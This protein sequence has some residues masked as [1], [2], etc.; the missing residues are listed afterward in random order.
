M[1]V[2]FVLL[3][4]DHPVPG[5]AIFNKIAAVELI[6]SALAAWYLMVHVIFTPLKFSIPAGKPWLK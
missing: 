2:G 5:A 6:V 1:F 3:D 4:V